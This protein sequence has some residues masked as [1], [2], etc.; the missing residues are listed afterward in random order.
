MSSRRENPNNKSI[1]NKSSH[2]EETIEETKGVMHHGV[3]LREW[4]PM[5]RDMD[6]LLNRYIPPH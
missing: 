5:W 4:Q 6:Q 3:H 1:A 2:T